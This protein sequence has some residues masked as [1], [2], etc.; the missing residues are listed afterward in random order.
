MENE[1]FSL[2]EQITDINEGLNTLD[3]Y[4]NSISD[5]Q[6]QNDLFISDLLHFVE[7]YE[8]TPKKALKFVNILKEK[9][10]ERRKL[11]NEWE[12]KKVYDNGKQRFT[13]DSQRDIFLNSIYKKEKELKSPYRYRVA[14]QEEIEEMIK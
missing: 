11:N 14:T 1:H 9:R 7:D 3:T 5:L 2:V 10:L 6:S 12:I 4:M 13:Y 8:F